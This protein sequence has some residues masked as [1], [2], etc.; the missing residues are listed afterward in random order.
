MF[1]RHGSHE[2]YRTLM[3]RDRGVFFKPRGQAQDSVPE[4]FAYEAAGGN[5]KLVGVGAGTRDG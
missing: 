1:P 4:D 5:L 3:N 2:S